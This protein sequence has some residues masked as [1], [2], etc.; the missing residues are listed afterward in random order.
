MSD[1]PL[2]DQV[3]GRITAAALDTGR[4]PEDVDL[5]AVSKLSLIHI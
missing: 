1:A 5:I 3:K 4:R 2:L